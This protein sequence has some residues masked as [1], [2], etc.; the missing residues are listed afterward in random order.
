MQKIYHSLKFVTEVDET[1]P[2]GMKLLELEESMRVEM[3][4]S[5]LKEMLAERIQPVLDE[6]NEGNTWATLKVAD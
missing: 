1:N 3:L 5:L 2:I 6:V 4:E